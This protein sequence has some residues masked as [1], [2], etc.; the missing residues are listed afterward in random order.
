MST[1][2]H[3]HVGQLPFI[4]KPLPTPSN[5]AGLPDSLPFALTLD[6]DTGRLCQAANEDVSTALIKAY[7]EG[8]EI[9]GMMDGEGIGRRY[10]EDFLSF[11]QQRLGSKTLAG[12]RVLE[13][14]CGNG[15]LLHRLKMLGAHVTGIEPG[16]H[17]SAGAARY[18][19]DIVC[20]YFPSPR[21]SGQFDLVILY[22]VLEHIESPSDFID[23]LLSY[24]APHGNVMLAVP[25]CTPYIE[26][27]DVSMLF[28]EHWSYFEQS[29]LS[30]LL[31]HCGLG[32][33]IVQTAGFGGLLYASVGIDAT[34]GQQTDGAGLA[35]RL[36]RAER[37]RELSREALEK[38]NV[39]LDNAVKAGHSLGVYVPSR[40]VNALSMTGSA[41][42]QF[43]FFD[44][45]SALI[46]TYFPGIKRAVESRSDLLANPTDELLIFSHTFGDKLKCDLTPLLPVTHI[47]TW[48]DLFAGF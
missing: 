22:C 37:Y 40:A 2:F 17:G 44:D 21:V 48:S 43:R 9:T 23:Q 31:R 7:S 5:F 19:I 34:T 47:S 27:G 38:L 45:N 10:A 15:Y 33:P 8:S 41:N 46:G 14:G 25:D 1:I 35:T 36:K 28:H 26:H 18:G 39:V 32:D 4:W 13:I 24:V 16:V 29:S 12:L 11:L 30:S 6:A 3:W 20:D 42:T